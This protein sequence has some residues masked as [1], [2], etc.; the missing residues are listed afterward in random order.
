MKVYFKILFVIFNLS[1]LNAL[2]CYSCDPPCLDGGKLVK[3][4]GENLACEV[5][6]LF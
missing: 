2:L 5:R 6:K 4:Y 3:C 1:L